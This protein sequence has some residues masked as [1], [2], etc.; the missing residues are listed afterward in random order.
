MILRQQEGPEIDLRILG[1][2]FPQGVTDWHDLN[3]L[4]IVVRVSTLGARW[5]GGPDP[6][7]LTTEARE[8]ARWLRSAADGHH[9]L[10]LNFIE[11]ELSFAV[12]READERG[13]PLAVTMRHAFVRN[14]P[15][16]LGQPD[17]LPF[18]LYVAPDVLLTAASDLEAELQR[19]PVREGAS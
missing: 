15:L 6:C 2:Q 7:L 16:V 3:W 10:P 1:Y 13:I 11:P 8:L 18:L 14:Q 19:Y 17:E 4:N 9:I 5:T 12:A